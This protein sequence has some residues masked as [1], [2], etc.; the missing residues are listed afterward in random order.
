M[1]KVF[2]TSDLHI[3]HNKDFVY[4]YRG[5]NNIAEHDE[6]LVSNWNRLVGADDVVYI[7]GDVMI[8]HNPQDNDFAY[9]ISVLE[10]LNGK[11]TIIRGNHDSDN[12]IQRYITC[13]NVVNAGDAALYLKYPAIGGYRFYLSHYPTLVSHKIS[14]PMK[15]ALINLFGHTHQKEHFYNNYPYMY[16][17]CMDAHEM[18]PVLLDDIIE[19]IKIKKFLMDKTNSTTQDFVIGN[20]T[21]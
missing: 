16:C 11:L 6:T 19:E 8:K 9:G 4:Q 2:I 12:K 14:G 17:V 15:A 7:L 3:G 13:Q 5:F 20:L 21:I 18:K 1:S 10:K